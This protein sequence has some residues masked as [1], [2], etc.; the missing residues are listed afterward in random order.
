MAK[1]QKWEFVKIS[2]SVEQSVDVENGIEISESLNC[3]NEVTMTRQLEH[4]D[5]KTECKIFNRKLSNELPPPLPQDRIFEVEFQAMLVKIMSSKT[6]SFGTAV[7]KSGL[8]KSCET[9][10]SIYFHFQRF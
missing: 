1:D 5:H 3:G 8:L 2:A 10:K 6:F 4:S 7:E 9:L